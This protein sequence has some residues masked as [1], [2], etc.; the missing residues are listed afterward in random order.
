MLSGFVIGAL[1]HQYHYLC[2]EP[3]WAADVLRPATKDVKTQVADF[4][5]VLCAVVK[6]M[7]PLWLL[8]W[9]GT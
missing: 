2:P 4:G 7:A 1:N 9:C 6:V 8:I 5:R 3:A